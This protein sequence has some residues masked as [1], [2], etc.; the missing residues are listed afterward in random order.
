MWLAQLGADVCGIA[1]DPPTDPSMFKE[2]KVGEGMRSEI[3]DIRDLE[4][5]KGILRE[6][7]P[8]VV[9]HMAA[10][11]LVR[12]SYDDPVGTYSTNVIGTVNVLD[13]IRGCDS[14]RGVVVVTTDKCYENKEWAWPYRETDRLGGY[15]PYSNSKA[16]A[17]L[18]VSAYRNSF[19]PPA[20]YSS[21]G[22]AIATARAGNV[23]GG[24]DWAC[25]RLVPDIMRAFAAKQ[26]L[27]IRNPDAVRPWQHVLEPLAGYLRLA[28]K[29]CRSGVEFGDAWNLG[30]ESS[31][32]KSVEWMVR[33]FAA[34]WGGQS[35][36]EIDNQLHPHEAQMLALDW[37]KASQALSWRPIMPLQHALRITAEWYRRW[38]AGE[39][40]RGLSIE[41][42]EQYVELSEIV[43]RQSMRR[44]AE[45][46]EK[47]E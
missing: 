6:H 26:V 38:S 42:I 18:V 19:F 16:C 34:H 37:S 25:D 14:V 32:A 30:S 2:A 15:D 41:Q 33:E 43:S 27:K 12:K 44:C 17:E 1:L 31:D 28:E 24:G 8:E 47:N 35:R 45:P 29:L 13:S 3:A 11:P 40:A 7:R 10:Q 22:V 20:S 46:T 5:V 23:I 39:D 36:W 21:H 9:F 4:R